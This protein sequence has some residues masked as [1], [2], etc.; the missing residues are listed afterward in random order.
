MQGLYCCVEIKPGQERK[1]AFERQLHVAAFIVVRMLFKRIVMGEK[2]QERNAGIH[3][4]M[5]FE[6]LK[7]YR[8]LQQLCQ[9]KHIGRNGN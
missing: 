1:M 6:M 8:G 7:K 3:L 2:I 5:F 9:G 4:P